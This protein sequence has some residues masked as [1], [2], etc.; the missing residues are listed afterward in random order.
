MAE[1]S[2]GITESPT[3]DGLLTVTGYAQTAQGWTVGVGSLESEV[4]RPLRNILWSNAVIFFALTGMSLLLAFLIARRASHGMVSLAAAA[5]DLGAGRALTPPVASFA[6][7]QT[8]G[9]E[10]A[11]ASAELR[12]RDALIARHQRDL[13]TEVA[14]RSD[15]LIAEIKRRH[16]AESTLRQSQKLESIGQLTGGIAH[17][18]NNALTVVMGNIDSAQRRLNTIEGAERLARPLEAALQGARNAARLTQRLL[19]FARQQALV[20]EAIDLNG[21]VANLSELLMRTVGETIRLETVASAGL[22]TVVADANQV[23]NALI[24]LAINARDAMPSGGRLTIETANAYLDEAY[25]DRFGDVAPGQYVMLSVSDSD[26]GVG[27]PKEVLERVFEPFF[28]TKP[29]GTGTGL[30]LAM[31]HGFVKQSGGHVRIYSE[32]GEGTTVK[33]Y[34]PKHKEAAKASAPPQRPAAADSS[35]TRARP[36]ECILVVED[37]AGVRAYAIDVLEDLGYTVLAAGSGPE[38]LQLLAIAPRIDLLFTDVVLPGGMNGRQLSEQVT[39]QR[40]GVPVLFT[41]GYTRNAIVHHGR[42]DPDVNLL[43]KPYT[44]R[45]L[46]RKVRALLDERAESEGSSI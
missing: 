42:L 16:E 17:D 36:G 46:A 43:T 4:A 19:A 24:N 1:R 40:A 38:A 9:A 6:E 2:D 34:L 18:F 45:E 3:V 12:R 10:L 25:A 41:T 26:S 31:V 13:E 22:W 33:I 44:R 15:E 27:M 23:E 8:I 21:L 11:T 7:A 14:L 37:E 35:D 29:A 32:V 28:T 39:A 20:P 30:G 5:K